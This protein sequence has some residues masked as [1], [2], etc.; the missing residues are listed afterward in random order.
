MYCKGVLFV[1]TSEEGGVLLHHKMM[2]LCHA[3]LKA[4]TGE[5]KSTL[6]ATIVIAG[7]SPSIQIPLILTHH[8]TFH[9]TKVGM[10]ESS[11]LC[12]EEED[13]C[14]NTDSLPCFLLTIH[15]TYKI[16][17]KL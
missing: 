9:S 10:V 16:L 8:I 1:L 14:V 17:F 11:V 12:V 6:G 13:S 3:A 5:W 4:R 15:D 2:P 7:S